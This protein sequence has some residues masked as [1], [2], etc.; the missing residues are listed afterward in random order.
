M[1]RL[2]CSISR[3]VSTPYRSARSSS[4][5]TWRSRTDQDA[6]L[7]SGSRNQ[8]Q[9]DLCFL[10]IG[11]LGGECQSTRT[12]P[13]FLTSQSAI[14]AVSGVP[15]EP[16]G[17]RARLDERS[18]TLRDRSQ[19]YGLAKAAFQ[20]CASHLRRVASDVPLGGR[21]DEP[22]RQ[23]PTGSRVRR[24]GPDFVP[25]SPDSTCICGDEARLSLSPR[26]ALVAIPRAYC[27][28]SCGAVQGGRISRSSRPAG[29]VLKGAPP[30]HDSGGT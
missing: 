19:R 8:F 13:C 17:L 25:P 10:L 3:R 20:A 29:H 27:Q 9:C 15:P 24:K 16:R 5:I 26:W 7:D 21:R 23:C 28:S 14:S 1:F 2:T 30:L 11:H 6:L 22:V 4:S 12:A 18:P